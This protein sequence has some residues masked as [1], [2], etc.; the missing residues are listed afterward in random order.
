MARARAIAGAMTLGLVVGTS[1]ALAGQQVYTYS[2]VHPIYGDIGTFTDTID[3]GAEGTRIDSHLRIAVKLLGVVAYREEAD[4]TEIMH[5]DRLVSLNSVTNKDG[6]HLEVHGE[7]KG[8]EFMVNCTLGTFSG[9]GSISPSDPWV[10]K[11]TGEEV[12]VSTS[13]GKIVHVHISGGDYDKVAMNGA[14]VTARHFVVSGD[15]R[16]EVWLDNREVP[17][18]FRT[19]E[20]GTPIDFVL[21]NATAAAGTTNVAALRRS[22]VRTENG[23]K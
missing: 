1:P 15:K 3:R 13:T 18:K 22:T 19:I 5:G 14:E 17:I 23:D 16:Q 7:A 9:P 10:L 20:D 12:V 21:Q 4:T 8:D 11:H 2:V 6:R